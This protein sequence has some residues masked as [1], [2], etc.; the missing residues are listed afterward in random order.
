V[1]RPLGGKSAPASGLGPREAEMLGRIGE[2][3]APLRKI[4]V[5]SG[6]LRTLNALA[7]RNLVQAAGFTPSDAAH[8][9]GLQDNWSVE[10]AGKAARL[11]LRHRDLAEPTPARID[12]FCREVWGE[13][14]RLSSRIVLEEALGQSLAGDVLADAVCRGSGVVG[15]GQVTITPSLPIVAVGAPARVY[16]GEVGRRLGADIVIPEHFEVAN[17]V[18]AAT[19]VVAHAVVVEVTGDGSG[20]FRVL[21]ASGPQGFDDAAEALEFAEEQA[22][23]QAAAAVLAMGA[24]APEI[25]VS[26]ERRMLPDDSLLQAAVTAEAIGRPQLAGA[27]SSIS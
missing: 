24:E 16:Y 5:T 13:V 12:S 27:G 10:A 25:R 1:L 26:I 8:V 18:G 2:A 19:G 23:E 17:A 22:R 14:A 3:P 11:M 7:R 4:A 6:G 20:R 15:L 9:L 21:G